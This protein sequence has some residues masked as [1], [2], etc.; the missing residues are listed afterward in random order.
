M[1]S[2]AAEVRV[3]GADREYPGW[4]GPPEWGRA[5]G[6]CA[7]GVDGARAPDLRPGRGAVVRQPQSE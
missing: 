5:R 4:S 7:E 2:A 6:W 3:P 1:V